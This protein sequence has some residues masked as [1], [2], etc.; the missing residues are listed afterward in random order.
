MLAP[1]HESEFIFWLKCFGMIPNNQICKNAA[2]NQDCNKA[3]SWVNY[4]AHDLYQWKCNNC[5]EKKS[6]REGS[7]FSDVKCN[8]N[9]VIRVLLGWCKSYDYE[10]LAAILGKFVDC[11]SEI[12]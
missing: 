7:V 9:N 12:Y 1:G 11:I 4:R 2:F 10:S 6:I 8:F 3:M 5:S